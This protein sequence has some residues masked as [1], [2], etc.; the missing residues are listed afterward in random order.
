MFFCTPYD[1]I[2][3]ANET[4]LRCQATIDQSEEE[5]GILGSVYRRLASNY[6]YQNTLL[7]QKNPG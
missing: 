7:P 3:F 5:N 4:T 2:T 6:S 1:V